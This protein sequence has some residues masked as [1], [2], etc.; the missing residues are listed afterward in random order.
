M[1]LP[2]Q[3]YKLQQ[4][5]ITLQ[6]KQQEISDIEG[7]LADNKALLAIELKLASQ[8]QELTDAEKRQKS[9]EWELQDTQEKINQ[10]RKKLYGGSVKNP[11]ELVNLEDDVKSLKK[12]LSRQEDELLELMDQVEHM[13]AEVELSTK[14]LEQLKQEWQQTQET[15][16]PRK[17]ETETEIASLNKNRQE[18]TQQIAPETVGLYEQLR[19]TKGQAVAKVEQGRCQGCRITLPVSQWQKAKTGDLVQCHS[20]SRILYL[21]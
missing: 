5:D 6:R 4:I 13:H 14:G 16:K 17:S 2:G 8:K 19:L 18:L 15:L 11:K 12:K 7:Q 10:V 9:A 1:N 21:E 20:C 3:L